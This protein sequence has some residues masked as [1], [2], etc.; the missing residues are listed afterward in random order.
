MALTQLSRNPYVRPDAPAR[1]PRTVE[2][3]LLARTTLALSQGW[4]RRATD[5]P[6][7]ALALVEN[8]QLWS[9]LAT[10]VAGP[11]NTL[12]GPL[13]A[14][15]FY[16]Y[17]FTVQHSRRVLEGEAGVEVLV[18]INTAVMKGLRGEAG[19]S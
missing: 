2:Y 19:A 6:A 4:R 8:Q 10:D 7:L 15:L 1:P 16:L 18:D 11:G 5:F 13:R 3:D 12:P 14:Q 9:A 17:E